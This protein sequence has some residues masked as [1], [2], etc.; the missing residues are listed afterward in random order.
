MNKDW[1]DITLPL[2]YALI[3]SAIRGNIIKQ[4]EATNGEDIFPSLK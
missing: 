4:S 2:I 3:E 1:N